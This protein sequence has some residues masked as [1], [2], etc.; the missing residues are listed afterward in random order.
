VDRVSPRL[1]HLDPFLKGYLSKSTDEEAT[2]TLKRL[3]RIVD[4]SRSNIYVN[5]MVSPCFTSAFTQLIQLPSISGKENNLVLFECDG[6]RPEEF[7]RVLEHLQLA[8]ATGFDSA[9][10]GLSPRGFGHRHTIHLW[11]AP[12]DYDGIGNVLFVSSVLEIDIERGD[13]IADANADA[14]EADAGADRAADGRSGAKGQGDARA[15][16]PPRQVEPDEAE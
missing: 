14:E 3:V 16:D 12:G 15:P 7:D 5:T 8:A 4:T 13:A 1:R 2:D 6:T 11:L 9:I 10:L